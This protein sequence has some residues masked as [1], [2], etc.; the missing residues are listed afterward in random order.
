LAGILKLPATLPLAVV[1]ENDVGEVIMTD[2]RIRQN[3]RRNRLDTPEFPF[4]DSRGKLVKHD[5]RQM[6]DRRLNNIEVEE[7]EEDDDAESA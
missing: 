4:R 2:K 3:D 5:R 7:I 1:N 6:P